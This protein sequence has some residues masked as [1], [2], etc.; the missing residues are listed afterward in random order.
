M[1]SIAV[2]ELAHHRLRAALCEEQ[3][4][5][6]G[7]DVASVGDGRHVEGADAGPALVPSWM[8][9]AEAWALADDVHLAQGVLCVRCT[10]S[11]VDNNRLVITTPK[12]RSSRGWIA[13]SPRVATALRRRSAHRGLQDAATLHPVD[14]R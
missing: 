10:L 13:N 5:S 11:A 8:P 4:R 2:G 1:T 6:V 3:R 12:T 14:D 9:V 7:K